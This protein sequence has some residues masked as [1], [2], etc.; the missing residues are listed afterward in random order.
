MFRRRTRFCSIRSLR[1]RPPYSLWSSFTSPSVPTC[2]PCLHHRTEFC[3][4]Y[5]SASYV[6]RVQLDMVFNELVGPVTSDIVIILHLCN[7]VALVTSNTVLLCFFVYVPLQSCRPCSVGHGY[8]FASL[9][10]RRPCYIEHCFVFLYTS[11]P[12]QSSRPCS[13]GRRLF[14]CF[15]V[16]ANLF[17]R[18]ASPDAVLSTLRP[19]KLVGLVASEMVFFPPLLPYRPRC[20]DGGFFSG[21]VRRSKLCCAVWKVVKGACC[22]SGECGY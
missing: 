6:G 3:C 11:V 19:N 12:L 16:S 14:F 15:S 20:V 18:V 7:P 5:V 21:R 17:G 9:Q 22:R 2:P 1:P 4:L 13:T 10:S 8:Y